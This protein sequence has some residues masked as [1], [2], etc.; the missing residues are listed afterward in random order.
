MGVALATKKR[1]AVKLFRY[2]ATGVLVVAGV[3]GAAAAV[4]EDD[5]AV[6]QHGAAGLPDRL[7]LLEE[8]PPDS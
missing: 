4:D 2:L 7:H 8:V 3:V 6:V 1:A 5:Q